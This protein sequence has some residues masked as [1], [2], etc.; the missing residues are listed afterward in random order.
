MNTI[1][2]DPVELYELPDHFDPF[3]SYDADSLVYLAMQ[4]DENEVVNT[5]WV[6]Q[7]QQGAES[8][9]QFC[10]D[11]DQLFRETF[12]QE[13]LPKNGYYVIPKPFSYM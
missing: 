5:L 10:R 3:I 13:A 1:Q 6:F 8:F 12:P 11:D 7:T 9:C 2:P 4:V